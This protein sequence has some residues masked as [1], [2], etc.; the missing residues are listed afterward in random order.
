MVIYFGQSLKNYRNCPHI[1]VTLF[2]SEVFTL[3]LTKNVLGYTLG[4][5][6]PSSSGHPAHSTAQAQADRH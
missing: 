4:D 5:F 1:W 6:F 2:Q 3:I